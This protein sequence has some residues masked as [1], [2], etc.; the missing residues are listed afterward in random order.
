MMLTERFSVSRNSVIKTKRESRQKFINTPNKG[1]SRLALIL[2][3]F[4]FNMNDITFN[5]SELALFPK[6]PLFVTS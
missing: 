2:V 3:I 5:Q 6:L 4:A 1:I